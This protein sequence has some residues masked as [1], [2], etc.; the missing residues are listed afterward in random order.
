MKYEAVLKQLGVN[1]LFWTGIMAIVLTLFQSDYYLL[2]F[3]V[4]LVVFNFAIILLVNKFAPKMLKIQEG[5]TDG[6]IAFTLKPVTYPKVLD[7]EKREYLPEFIHLD[8][9][10]DRRVIFAGDMARSVLKQLRDSLD[11]ALSVQEVKTATV[12]KLQTPTVKKQRKK[13]ALN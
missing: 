12:E 5:T 8:I 1:A 2:L 3:F 10:K 13:S 7:E 9:A 11:Q 4:G 6:E